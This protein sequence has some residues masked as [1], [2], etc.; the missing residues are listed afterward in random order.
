VNSW[1]S[2]AFVPNLSAVETETTIHVISNLGSPQEQL[3][4]QLVLFQLV[5]RQSFPLADARLDQGNVRVAGN[6]GR[7]EK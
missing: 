6:S 3:E 7:N 2:R 5:G 1:A 4:L